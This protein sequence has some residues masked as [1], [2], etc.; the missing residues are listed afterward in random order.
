MVDLFVAFNLKVLLAKMTPDYSLC[1][2]CF[3]KFGHQHDMKKIGLDE[4]GE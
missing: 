2:K 1:K 3:E 4:E